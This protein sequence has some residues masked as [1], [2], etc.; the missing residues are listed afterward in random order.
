MGFDEKKKKFNIW[1]KRKPLS[2]S[3]NLILMKNFL[4]KLLVI[5]SLFNAQ[6][7]GN[8]SVIICQTPF[9]IFYEIVQ[10]IWGVKQFVGSRRD[11]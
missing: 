8:Q 6:D 2:I 3:L 9:S 11:K 4:T 1:N 5:K 7:Q 10:V